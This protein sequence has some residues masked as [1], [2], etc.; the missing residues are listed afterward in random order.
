M[1]IL[2]FF[3]V[4]MSLM[5]IMSGCSSSPRPESNDANGANMNIPE[6]V[7]VDTTTIQEDINPEELD[8]IDNDLNAL[9][10]Y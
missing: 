8:S 6:D 9:E 7:V 10:N 2:T 1:K 3:T 5:F 4:L